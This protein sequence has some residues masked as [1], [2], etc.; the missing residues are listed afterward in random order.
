MRGWFTLITLL[1]LGLAQTSPTSGFFRITATQ[2]SAAATPGAWRYSISL[3]TYEARLLWRQH[4]P[5]WQQTL[6]QRGRAQLGA[7]ALRFVG[8]KLVLEPG[9]PV[10]NPSCFTRTA[11]AIPA[12]QQDAVLLDFSNTLVQAIREGTQR[13][14]PYPATLTVSKL[15]RLQLNSDGTYSAAPSG[16]RP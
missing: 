2:S 3:K 14:K 6:R 9:C 16:W 11:T 15:V 5:F 1:G 13:A 7:Y 4:L 8:G 10:P 12:W